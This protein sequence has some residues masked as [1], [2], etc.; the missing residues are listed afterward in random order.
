MGRRMARTFI[1]TF[2]IY[3]FTIYH[4]AFP[5]EQ[6][7]GSAASDE[8]EGFLGNPAHFAVGDA[9]LAPLFEAAI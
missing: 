5:K 8:V 3:P 1:N 7:N 9:H 6:G 2:T 4:L